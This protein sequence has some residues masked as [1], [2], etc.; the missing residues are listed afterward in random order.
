[1]PLDTAHYSW[2]YYTKTSVE[3]QVKH[4]RK[5][6]NKHKR[7]IERTA[8]FS[9]QI[10]SFVLFLVI[11]YSSNKPSFV[12]SQALGQKTDRKYKQPGQSLGTRNGCESC[13]EHREHSFSQGTA[14]Y[15][16][17]YNVPIRSSATGKHCLQQ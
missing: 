16:F 10:F 13:A 12:I 11:Q 15:V 1:M 9:R 5:G 4:W 3:S 2:G 8:L 17:C 6:T 14:H 7:K